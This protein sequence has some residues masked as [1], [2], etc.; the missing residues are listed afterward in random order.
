MVKRLI[1]NEKYMRGEYPK[2]HEEYT[3]NDEELDKMTPE[4]LKKSNRDLL[5]GVSKYVAGW[6]AGIAIFAAV[7]AEKNHE[8]K[9]LEKPTNTISLNSTNTEMS[10]DETIGEKPSDIYCINNTCIPQE[11]IPIFLSNMSNSLDNADP[12]AR[13]A[14]RVAIE[15]LKGHEGFEDLIRQNPKVLEELNRIEL[16]I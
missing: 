16:K 12:E 9:N 10:S 15:N 14:A 8:P 3:V 6:M 1:F 2:N 7:G 13:E 11:N 4:E 5:K